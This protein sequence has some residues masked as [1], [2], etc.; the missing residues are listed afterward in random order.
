MK[1]SS[2]MEE[3]VVMESNFGFLVAIWECGTMMFI[4]VVENTVVTQDTKD[5]GKMGKRKGMALLLIWM[6]VA[7]LGHGKVIENKDLVRF[8]IQ[9]A[10]NIKDNG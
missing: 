10:E 1:E 6:E 2:K 5:N 9:M 8:L 3:N 4:M 7:I